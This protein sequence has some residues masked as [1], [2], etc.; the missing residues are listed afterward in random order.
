M[1]GEI[2]QGDVVAVG[3]KTVTHTGSVNKQLQIMTLTD[4]V[5]LGKLIGGVKGAVFGRESDVY[6]TGLGH[7]VA[8]LVVFKD[9]HEVGKL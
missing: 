1:L 9:V 5:D 4:I 8:A 3:H 2:G 7:V 6:H